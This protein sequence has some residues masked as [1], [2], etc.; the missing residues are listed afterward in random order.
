M[1]RTL[2]QIDTALANIE[3]IVPTLVTDINALHTTLSQL[4]LTIQSQLNTMAAQLAT[5]TA[6]VIALQASVSALILPVGITAVPHE[7]LTGYDAT[8]GDFTMARP[9]SIDLTWVGYTVSLLPASPANGA[10][11]Y[12]TNGLKIGETTGNGTGVLVYASGGSWYRA[13]DDTIVTS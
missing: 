3:L 8:T 5:L 12:A 6:T 4:V 13:S 1:T 10:V 7:F 11:S 9:S 2:E